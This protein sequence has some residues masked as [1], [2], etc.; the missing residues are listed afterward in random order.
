MM[1]GNQD[2]ALN[3]IE[4]GI[5]HRL[6]MMPYLYL[7]PVLKPL[8]SISRF[9]ELMKKIIREK[10]F[11][12]FSKKE[13]QESSLIE[14]N[15]QTLISQQINSKKKP[16]LDAKTDEASTKK[17]LDLITTKEPFLDFNLTLKK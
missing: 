14:E 1:M 11:Q 2:A 13:P 17:L 6:P 4:E 8:Y 9:R 7:E 16:L 3:L 15:N 12:D 5:G 10:Y